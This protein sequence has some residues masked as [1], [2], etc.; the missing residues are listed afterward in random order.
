MRSR[1]VTTAMVKNS[2][3]RSDRGALAGHAV[4]QRYSG[5]FNIQRQ[6]KER[7]ADMETSQSPGGTARD[8]PEA[9]IWWGMPGGPPAAH[10][11]LGGCVVPH[12]PQDRVA[13]ISGTKVD[14]GYDDAEDQI[15]VDVKDGEGQIWHIRWDASLQA[16]T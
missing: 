11:V 13:Q 6:R 3:S 1:R 10:V 5:V 15:W 14:Q 4:L 9:E 16:S 12:D 2:P 8:L 7:T